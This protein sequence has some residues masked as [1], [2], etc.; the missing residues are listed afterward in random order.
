[1]TSQAGL[2]AGSTSRSVALLVALAA[3]G[4][5]LA[6]CGAPAGAQSENPPG[7]RELVR[8]NPG[9][10]GHSAIDIDF[11]RMMVVHTRQSIAMVA[12]VAER[13]EQPGVVAL[14]EQVE[15]EDAA[16]IEEM[17]A[18]LATWGEDVPDEISLTE[19]DH[20]RMDHEG[21]GMGF[22]AGIMPAEKMTLLAA[23]QG[24]PFDRMFLKL[25]RT[26]HGAAIA[27][28]QSERLYG[29]SADAIKIAKSVESD[30]SEEMQTI[31]DL[32]KAI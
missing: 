26:H 15:A 32:L 4:I 6:G 17:S 3:S 13:S 10:P 16:T 1:M 31:E 22:M 25:M 2:D 20:S 9:G 18:L 24:E 29:D 8:N 5:A 11:A 7:Y 12:L 28:A 27:M 14:A 19:M 30:E 21:I 23:T